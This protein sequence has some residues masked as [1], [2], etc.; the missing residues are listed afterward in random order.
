LGQGDAEL[1]VRNTRD[2]SG[3]FT[4]EVPVVRSTVPLL[5]DL[6]TL[7]THVLWLPF[8]IG[9]GAAKKQLASSAQESGYPPQSLSAEQAPPPIQ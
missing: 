7:S 8:G 4:L 2:A 6:K 5:S 9:N 3:I 1:A